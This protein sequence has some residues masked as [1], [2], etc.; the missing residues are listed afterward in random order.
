MT[1]SFPSA[2]SIKTLVST[3]INGGFGMVKPAINNCHSLIQE[4]APLLVCVFIG[5]CSR[6][7]GN[8]GSA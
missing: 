5:F 8:Y 4:G 1:I 3:A 6:L 7:L 2:R